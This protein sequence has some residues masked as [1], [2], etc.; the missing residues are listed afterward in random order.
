MGSM[1]RAVFFVELLQATA[2]GAV[3]LVCVVC[4]MD[5]IASPMWMQGLHAVPSVW[6]ASSYRGKSCDACV[7]PMQ[8]E[9]PC[10]TNVSSSVSNY[11]HQS[12]ASAHDGGPSSRCIKHDTPFPR[13]TVQIPPIQGAMIHRSTSV[14]Q[15]LVI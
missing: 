8:N 11:F 4:K 5:D 2:A 14:L 15:R 7:C 6:T 9:R 12:G 1:S 3:M 10:I 13:G